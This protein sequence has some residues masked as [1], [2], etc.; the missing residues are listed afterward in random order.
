MNV[1]S[2][3]GGSVSIINENSVDYDKNSDMLSG[4]KSGLLQNQN[5]Q[6][7]LPI[8]FCLKEHCKMEEN[9]IF[10]SSK[11][12]EKFPSFRKDVDF[13]VENTKRLNKFGLTWGL[14]WPYQITL[15]QFILKTT[16]NRST[17]IKFQEQIT[18]SRL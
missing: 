4:Y 9:I 13:K 3:V 14:H 18:L 11:R 10:I 7:P 2:S 5:K 12:E 8:F 1:I 17:F 16:Q 15:F 6:K